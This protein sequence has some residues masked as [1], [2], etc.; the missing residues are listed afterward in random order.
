MSLSHHPRRKYLAQTFLN[1][2]SL[3]S[4]LFLALASILMF[5]CRSKEVTHDLRYSSDVKAQLFT[6]N[7]ASDAGNGEVV[8][9][10]QQKFQLNLN[11]DSYAVRKYELTSFD[12]E[13]NFYHFNREGKVI[14]ELLGIQ[15]YQTEIDVTLEEGYNKFVTEIKVLKEGLEDEYSTSYEIAMDSKA[16]QF[17]LSGIAK[18]DPLTARASIAVGVL[19]NERDISSCSEIYLANAKTGKVIKKYNISERIR[20]WSEKNRG[21]QAINA[22][23]PLKSAENATANLPL[24]QVRF[25]GEIVEGIPGGI[26][27]D[28]TLYATCED[29]SGNFAKGQLPISTA[30]QNQ[31]YDLIV[32]I[33]NGI[34]YLNDHIYRSNVEQNAYHVVPS[35]SGLEVSPPPSNAGAGVRDPESLIFVSRSIEA[36]GGV[37]DIGFQLN[38]K[39]RKVADLIFEQ[40]AFYLSYHIS[41]IPLTEPNDPQIF[42]QKFLAGDG[43]QYDIESNGLIPSAPI[44]VKNSFKTL[45]DIYLSVV[46]TDPF[47]KKKTFMQNTDGTEIKNIKM[48]LALDDDGIEISNDTESTFALS[49][50]PDAT[51]SDDKT[52]VKL[53]YDYGYNGAPIK[54]LTVEYFDVDAT[55]KKGTKEKDPYMLELNEINRN[56]YTWSS[57]KNKLGYPENSQ[58]EV[59]KKSFLVSTKIL[60]PKATKNSEGIINYTGK[61][62]VYLS[63]GKN[64]P[65]IFRVRVKIEDYAGNISVSQHSN[66]L[67]QPAKKFRHDNMFTEAIRERCNNAGAGYSQLVPILLNHSS[68]SEGTRR[69]VPVLLLNQG[70]AKIEVIDEVEISPDDDNETQPKYIK[71]MVEVNGAVLPKVYTILNPEITPSPV[72]HQWSGGRIEYLEIEPE[73][74]QNGNR[75]RFIFDT[76]D[77]IYDPSTPPTPSQQKRY[78]AS[79]I[80]NSCYK[81][82]TGEDN[83]Y[84]SLLVQSRESNE[85]ISPDTN[86]ASG[87]KVNFQITNFSCK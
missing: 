38:H 29:F 86:I 16:P 63:S 70:D 1:R 18:I 80:T 64:I 30:D 81:A 74:F 13:L 35:T 76:N 46:K 8:K 56:F 26:V 75:V 33:P 48:R 72:E 51:K 78:G 52:V 60:D 37:F 67:F 23:K 10:S 65:A 50:E 22:Y 21:D 69:A 73:W 27:N 41:R 17:T 59:A 62:E 58:K 77:Q 9:S 55:V 43:I 40:Q 82:P 14:Y 6:L 87:E 31:K 2:K 4:T 28:L 5:G 24:E 36:G 84:P 12:T 57:L 34:T 45:Q 39:A 68:C 42:A 53:S 7:V 15:D 20:E 47:S 61:I 19:T 85:V 44:I 3:S 66:Y 49:P 71:Y 25:D 11:L 79:S 54:N 32:A 83:Y